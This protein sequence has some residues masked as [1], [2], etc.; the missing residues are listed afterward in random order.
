MRITSGGI[1]GINTT[2]TTGQLNL[3]GISGIY[4]SSTGRGN[5]QIYFGTGGDLLFYNTS[6]YGYLSAAGSWINA[7]DSSIK[8][9]IIDIKY[10]INDV[11]KLKPRSYKMKD[12]N[13][14]EIG[15]IA[16]EVEGVIP[17]L[18]NDAIG[19][20]VKGLNYGNMVSLTVKSIQEQQILIQELSAQIKE[21]SAKN[22]ALIKRIETLENK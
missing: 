5:R 7:S 19:S 4:Y 22:E 12:G 1:I 14:E 8:K 20:G 21:L 17:E 11:M 9:D 10:N 16:Q 15:F 2:A 18:V 3:E 6:N 13:K